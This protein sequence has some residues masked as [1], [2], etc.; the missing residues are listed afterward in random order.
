MAPPG[1]LA[2][3]VALTA[4]LLFG[5]PNAAAA[6]AVGESGNS[7]DSIWRVA[8]VGLYLDTSLL[9]LQ[10]A[11]DALIE[12]AD[13]WRAAD[14]RLPHVWPIVGAAD[15]LGYREGQDNR[16]T[17]R[18][19]ADGEPLAQGALAIT[20]VTYDSEQ[21]TILDADIVVNGA[22]KFDNNGQYCGQRGSTGEGNAYDIGDVLAHEMGH[23]F[24]LPDDAD[25]P[26][27]IMYPYFDPGVTRRKTLSEGDRQALNDLYSHDANGAGKPAACSAAGGPGR[28]GSAC[29]FAALMA[30]VGV[31]RLLRRRSKTAGK[32]AATYDGQQAAARCLPTN[33]NELSR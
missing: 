26:T 1:S 32:Q 12:A 24:G 9:E 14:P 4:I 21:S 29:D 17:V 30:L 27:A 25:D 5:C 10:G 18:Y 16:N 3:K 2:A 28:S 20:V 15:E 19:A 13:T 23:W 22:Y 31:T 7:H 11:T 6:I 33:L 8:D